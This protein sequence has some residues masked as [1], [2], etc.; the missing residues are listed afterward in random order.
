MLCEICCD[1][2]IKFLISRGLVM[3]ILR[4]IEPNTAEQRKSCKFK[5]RKYLVKGTNDIWYTDGLDKLQP[6]SLP[7]HAAIKGFS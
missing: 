6:H 2:N 5:R 7:F 1:S 4:G 3:S